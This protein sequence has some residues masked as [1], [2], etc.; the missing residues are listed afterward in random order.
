MAEVAIPMAVLG[1]M[2][3]ISNK[4]NEIEKKEA[5]TNNTPTQPRV[6]NYPKDEKKD[7][8]NETNVQTYQGYKNR[9]ENLYQPTGYKKALENNENK[10]GEIQSLTGNSAKF[11][12][13]LRSQ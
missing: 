9:N 3:I 4:D 5:F 8:L 1:V 11:S 10:V 6:I 7:L 2:Y 12:S 13:L